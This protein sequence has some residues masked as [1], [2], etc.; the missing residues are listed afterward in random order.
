[1]EGERVDESARRAYWAEQMDAAYAFMNVVCDHPVKECGEPLL[2]LPE[3]AQAAGVN[4]V[5]STTT[6]GNGRQRLFYLREGLIG[7][8]VAVAREM[9]ARGWLLKVED[10]YR[11]RAIQTELGND[12]KVF[13]V[14]LRRVI[15]ELGGKRPSAELMYRRLSAL[16]ATRPKV[17]THTCG[18]A[19]DI[20]V[21]R[22]E[23][24]DETNR[25]GPYLELSERTPMAS[26]FV[27]VEA[28]RHRQEI[29]ELMARQ[30]FVAYPY[31]FWHY[32][33]GDAYHAFLSGSGTPAR[34]GAVDMNPA[35]GRTTPLV[36]PEE[37]LHTFDHIQ[38]E[39]QRALQRS[40]NEGN[41][42]GS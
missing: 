9:N 30:G 19:L 11:T 34:Y 22:L 13:D 15:W 21:L 41:S 6:V 20:S 23:D 32:S 25:G 27:S 31:E 26:P 24:G 42:P 17:G 29:T 18:S 16:I 33:E 3:A 35:D 36:H 14:I 5:F 7:E 40:R 10:G 2:P 4:V 1:M 12:P 38:E 8:F 28:Q 39:I 37:P